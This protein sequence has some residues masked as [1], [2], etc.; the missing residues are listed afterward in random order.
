[1]WTELILNNLKHNSPKSIRTQ[2][3]QK[4]IAD[5]MTSEVGKGTS[6]RVREK[7]DLVLKTGSLVLKRE[8]R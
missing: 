8:A 3:R 4:E 5:G 7:R 6:S 1:M 2:V